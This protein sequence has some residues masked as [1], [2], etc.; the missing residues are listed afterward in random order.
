[1]LKERLNPRKSSSKLHT[2]VSAHTHSQFKRERKRRKRRGR[3]RRSR[4]SRKR[5]RKR[6]LPKII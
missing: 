4:R 5:R 3:R 1:M 2:S 6:R